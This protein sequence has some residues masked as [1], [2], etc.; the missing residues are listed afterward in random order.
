MYIQLYIITGT[1]I[2]QCAVIQ[3]GEQIN[4]LYL[5]CE[6]KQCINFEKQFYSSPY[7]EMPA[8]HY[9]RTYKEMDVTLPK[10]SQT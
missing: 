6:K 1:S 2:K 10:I 3:G 9:P 5:L 8:C 7:R 4:A